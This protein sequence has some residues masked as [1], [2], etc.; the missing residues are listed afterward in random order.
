MYDS[1]D[2]KVPRWTPLKVHM[3]GNRAS[4]FCFEVVFVHTAEIHDPSTIPL[5]LIFRTYNPHEVRA[6]IC[7]CSFRKILG[8]EE[9]GFVQCI[10]QAMETSPVRPKVLT[11][12][13]TL[14][15]QN[16]ALEESYTHDSINPASD[17]SYFFS[18]LKNCQ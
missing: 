11:Q 4:N 2:I 15:H 3:P 9:S 10:K 14:L 17:P 5:I 13:V 1:S 8:T 18:T 16:I 6:N 7:F 12:L